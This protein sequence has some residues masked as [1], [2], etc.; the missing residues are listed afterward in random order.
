MIIN[1]ELSH[2]AEYIGDIQENRV[3]IDKDN[4]DFITTLL[5]S[6][7]YS[8]PLD[9]FFRETVSN[10]YDSHMEAGTNDPVLILIQDTSEYRRYRISIR[11]YGT[12]LSPERFDTIYRN[13]GSSTKRQ[14]NDY[15]GMFGIGRFSCLSC[16]DTASIISYYNGT[17][18]SYVMYKN[19]GGINIDK[20]SE[21]QGEFKNGLEVCIEKDIYNLM[22]LR[23]SINSLC[24]FKHL[25]VVYK[26]ENYIIQNIEEE[27]NK[28]VVKN[29]KTFSICSIRP[30]YHA[31]FKMGNVLY[32]SEKDYVHT[33]GLF[34]DLPMGTVDITPN[35]E[36]LQFTS[37][38]ETVI[39]NQVQ[40]VKRELSELLKE[41]ANRKDHTLTSLYNSFVDGR[42]YKISPVP[43]CQ[44]LQLSIDRRDCNIDTNDITINGEL[45]PYNYTKYLEFIQ[46]LCL[47]AALIH[48]T[49]NK[50]P[51]RGVRGALFS[52]ILNE[53]ITLA[54]KVDKVT[55]E[56]TFAHFKDS[57]KEKA[58]ILVYE[59]KEQL[60]KF[61]NEQAKTYWF[62]AG[63]TDIE[64]CT[65]Y[66]LKHLN[67][68]ELDNN[69][70]PAEYLKNFKEQ[71]K[72]KRKKPTGEVPIRIYHELGYTVGDLQRIMN[73]KGLIIYTQ[74]T[75]DDDVLKELS[76]IAGSG[77]EGVISLKQEYLNLV[78]SNRKFI[79]INTFMYMKHPFLVKLATF[80]KISS[81][82][83]LTS[84]EIGTF[85]II[86]EFYKKYTRFNKSYSR[87]STIA[88]IVKYYEDK[89]WLNYCDINYYKLNEK[90]LEALNLWKRLV[91][92]K[93]SVIQMLLYKKYGRMG[94]IGIVPC[95]IP[96]I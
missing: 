92:D 69:T 81:S 6:N 36:T 19:G 62:N 80:L 46:G 75:K 13:I 1:T 25:H 67:I 83:P 95:A 90:E 17:K 96:K 15:I 94:K 79:H 61:L 30:S 70:V 71:A 7:L 66:T 39:A 8:K 53:E 86:K 47:D 5:T 82:F 91:R 59:G 76:I 23:R 77:V 64:K 35:R 87:N 38:T 34:I 2:E 93:N 14:S 73:R 72:S 21:T 37:T 85:P 33:D 10:A 48:K 65:D 44:A 16:A 24:L 52:S 54:V 84:Y 58:I 3:G 43:E 22:D 42:Y 27:F 28:R 57:V 50:T 55:K 56:V 4:V 41:E 51:Y 89:G 63:I 20:I 26:G 45:V 60:K 32:F 68:I 49:V 12:G 11:D 78:E 40:K 29:Y 74:H 18:Y 9:S 88:D 31:T